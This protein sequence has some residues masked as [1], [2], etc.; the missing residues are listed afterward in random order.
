[1]TENKSVPF[2]A[3]FRRVFHMIYSL[4]DQIYAKALAKVSR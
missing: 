3:L 1:M 4:A 2:F